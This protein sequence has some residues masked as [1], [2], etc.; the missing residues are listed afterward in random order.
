MNSA[1]ARILKMLE[2][3]KITADEATRL[4]NALERTES[5]SQSHRFLKVRVFPAG[6]E[7]PKVNI[8]VPIA[9]LKWG[10]KLVP[11]SAKA[12]IEEKEIDLKL[13]SE[14][15]ESGLTGKIVDIQDDE[16]NEHIEVWIE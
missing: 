7:K 9:L 4:L 5:T 15:F 16:K 3:K 11:E 2:E 6:S 14:A 10:M 13:L 12:K 1:R 8:T